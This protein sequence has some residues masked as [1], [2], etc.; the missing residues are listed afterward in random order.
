MLPDADGPVIVL[1]VPGPC[2][3]ESPD[4][5]TVH[6]LIA[7]AELL[8]EGHDRASEAAERSLNKFL[9]GPRTDDH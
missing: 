4:A 2:A 3:M 8:E 9:T 1:R 7:W 6:P 5:S